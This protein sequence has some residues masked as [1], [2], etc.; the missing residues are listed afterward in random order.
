MEKKI[1][2]AVLYVVFVLANSCSGGSSV[3][4]LEE[5]KTISL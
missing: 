4:E 5:V 2:T 3:N 1:L